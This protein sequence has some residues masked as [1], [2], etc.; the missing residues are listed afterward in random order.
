MRILALLNLLKDLVER[1]LLLK[2]IIFKLIFFLTFFSRV[3]LEATL[4]D[5]VEQR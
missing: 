2:I 3:V 4:N 5:W 1:K